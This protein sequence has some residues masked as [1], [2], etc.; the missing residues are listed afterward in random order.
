MVNPSKEI[1]LARVKFLFVDLPTRVTLSQDDEGAVPFP[2]RAAA[3][4]SDQM[5]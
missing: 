3:F 1:A 2:A 4:R 5:P